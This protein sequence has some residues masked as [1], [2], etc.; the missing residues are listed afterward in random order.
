MVPCTGFVCLS[1]TGADYEQD[2][3]GWWTAYLGLLLTVRPK[4]RSALERT[5]EHNRRLAG[6]CQTPAPDCKIGQTVWH[7]TCNLHLQTDSRRMF[8]KLSGPHT[9]VKVL[10]PSPVR[11]CLCYLLNDNPVFH[12]SLLKPVFHVSLLKPAPSTTTSLP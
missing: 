2:A 11:L 4:T 3:P 12:V 10:N 7:S 8:P 6:C 9:I 5:A 1:F